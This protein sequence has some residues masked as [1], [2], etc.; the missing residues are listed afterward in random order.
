MNFSLDDVLNM[1]PV[2]ATDVH[3]KDYN[4]YKCIRIADNDAEEWDGGCIQ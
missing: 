3:L 4:E 1:W 2:C